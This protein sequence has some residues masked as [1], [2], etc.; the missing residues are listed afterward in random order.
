MTLKKMISRDIAKFTVIFT[1]LE[2]LQGHIRTQSKDVG[3]EGLSPMEIKVG[4]DKNAKKYRKKQFYHTYLQRHTKEGD[5]FQEILSGRYALRPELIDN[6][7]V[8]ELELLRDEIS[9]YW[10]ASG[11]PKQRLL[12]NIQTLKMLDLADLEARHSFIREQLGSQDGNAGQHLEIMAYSILKEYFSSLGFSLR[13]FSTTFAND[14]GMDFISS[15]AFYQV[16]AS[17]TKTKIALDLSKLPGVK[18]VLIAPGLF[19]NHN[20]LDEQDNVL[21]T[22]DKIDLEEHFLDWLYTKDKKRKRAFH[23]QGILEIAHQEY[24]RE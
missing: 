23:L 21:E 5:Y 3:F 14:G 12:T 7:S 8:I 16:T 11:E 2:V 19:G 22:I 1:L 4:Y 10:D 17:P 24:E 20:F 6:L 15:D 18:R 9:D 13:R